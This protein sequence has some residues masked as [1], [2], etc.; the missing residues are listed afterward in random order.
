MLLGDDGS[1]GGGGGG[2]SGRGCL[3]CIINSKGQR[4]STSK[5]LL[6]ALERKRKDKGYFKTIIICTIY[7]T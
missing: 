7:C 6:F 4:G 3:V 5:S 1:R 2:N